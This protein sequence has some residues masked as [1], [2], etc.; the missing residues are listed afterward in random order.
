MTS[1][2]RRDGACRLTRDDAEALFTLRAHEYGR[3]AEFE[4]LY[5][6]MLRWDDHDETGI[7]LGIRHE[8]ELVA[9]LRG[10][11]AM[12]RPAAEELFC[13]S[14]A[15]TP[16]HFP[17]L[18]FGRGATSARFQRQGLNALLRLYVLRAVEAEGT[19]LGSSLALPYEGAP[20]VNLL[21]SLGYDIHRPTSTWDV[22][23]RERTPMLLAVLPRER[24]AG[25]LRMLE[26]MSQASL[27][28]FPWTD[29]PL[30]IAARVAA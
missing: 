20:R 26:E 19:C 12:D 17:A 3:A 10:V 8:G 4:M 16:D 14:V 5:P 24:F 25:A 23:A 29:E 21:K 27:A 28:R 7:V 11:I 13:C 30:R 6:E 1:G 15:L 22:E 2:Q 9:T 18:M